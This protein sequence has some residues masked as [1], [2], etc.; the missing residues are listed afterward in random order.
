MKTI[1]IA[2]L[3]DET[4]GLKN[5][6]F[7]GVGKINATLKT[8][9]LIIEYGPDR[10]VNFGTAGS[11]KTNISGLVKCTRFVQRDM[12]VRGLFDF[13]LGET[14]FEDITDI[15]FG[16][17]GFTCGTGDNFAQST[18]DIECDLVDMEAYAIAKVC[19]IKNVYF[20]CYKYVSD[21][22]NKQSSY[23]WGVNV[24]KG[25]KL[26]ADKFNESRI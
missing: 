19:K 7:T 1:F 10:I 13:V 6:H 26:F 9:E 14:P 8:V 20:E 4:K 23:D 24:Q 2:A 12:D 17:N 16:D 5:F 15:Q 25:A 18:V 11:T 3:Q 21:Y 22:I